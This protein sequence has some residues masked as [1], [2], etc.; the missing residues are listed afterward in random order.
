MGPIE[1]LWGAVMA[2]FIILGVMRG[3]LKELGLTTVMIVWLF[4]MDQIIPRLEEWIRQPDSLPGR[5]GLTE[6]TRDT[7]LW[8]IFTLGTIVVVYIAYQ[9]ETLAFEGKPP[10]GIQ[11]PVLSLLIGAINGYLVCGT[12][13]WILNRY[14]YPIRSLGLFFDY[15]S[16]AGMILSPAA[17]Q[18]VNVYRLLPL[19][20]LGQGVESA[21]LQGVLPLLVITLVLLRVLR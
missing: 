11:G 5:I 17:N 10:K 14:N 19:D 9:G 18:I 20:L 13:W 16:A 6:A 1:G 12:L 4:A 8:L 15:N 2:I 3:F 21:Q 7:P